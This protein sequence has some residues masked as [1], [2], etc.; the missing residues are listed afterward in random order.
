MAPAAPP[1]IP[2]LIA[3]LLWLSSGL[4]AAAEPNRYIGDKEC[5]QCHKMIEYG[6]YPS[7]THGKIF[8]T[9]PRNAQERLGCEGCHGQGGTHAK[10]AGEDETGP[11]ELA[12][13]KPKPE[14]VKWINETCLSCHEGGMR[15]E[16]WAGSKHQLNDLACTSCHRLHDKTEK[17]A[18]R[19]CETCHVKERAKMARSTHKPLREEQMGCK[20]CH[21][22]H[23]SAGEASLQTANLNDTCYRCHADKRGPFLWEHAPV[24]DNC[25]TCHDS[26]GSNQD[27]MLKM[28]LPYLCQS[29]HMIPNA[30]HSNMFDGQALSSL[31]NANRPIQLGNS[32]T[33]C[34]ASIHGSNHPSGPS[35]QR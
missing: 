34:H 7:S 2:F 19:V 23:G 24:R 5:Y 3:L 6:G 21:N 29:C 17:V 10:V 31:T 28:R 9:A 33:N 13:F 27:A 8:S 22:A 32:C 30:G 15:V 35:F 26:H 1:G 12:S 18:Q 16:H 20:S 4:A 25:A 11:M 14:N